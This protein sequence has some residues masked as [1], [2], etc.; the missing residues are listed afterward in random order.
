[1]RNASSYPDNQGPIEV[2]ETH[3]SWVFLTDRYAYKLKKPVRF[4][5]LDFSIPDL[6]HRACL[7]EVRL[8]R[9][10]APDVYL[11]VLPITQN[12]VG[13]IT[14]N[15]EGQPVDW[16]VQMRRLPATNA[17][18]AVLRAGKLTSEQAQ[19]IVQH[20]TSSYTRLLPKPINANVYREA[21]NR[22]IRANGVALLGS[23]PGEQ[24]RTRRIQ[25]AQ[26]RYLNVGADLI[27][28]RATAGRVVEGHG[29]L[30]P[31]H[32]YVNGG[33]IVIDCIEFSDELR[34]VDI[35]DELSFLGME[36]E[37]LGD[38]GLGEAVLAEYQRVSGDYLP[39]SLLSFYRCYR[40]LVRAKV[41]LIRE[42]QQT[43]DAASLS[44]DLVH[45]YIDLADRYAKQLG[46]PILLIVGGLM[47]SGK[48]TLAAKLAEAFGSEL[49][50]TDQIRHGLMGASE[51]PAGYGEG[52]YRPDMRSRVYDE[53]FRQ[54]GELLKDG[55]SVVLD[56]TFLT[57]CLR[58][59]AYDLGRRS[60]AMC[61]HMHCTCPRQVAYARIQK[62]TETGQSQSEA[63]TELYD[64]QAQDLEPPWADE[65]T[66]TVD[67]TSAV[68]E[69]HQA[70][71][72][73]LK[74]LASA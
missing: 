9:R 65:P 17:L 28:S 43:N 42:Q 72:A 39:E 3:I 71:Y 58:D 5:F 47:G 37:R 26:L 23:L 20:L 33:P 52:N 6:R 53:L 40:A 18:D 51:S 44:A 64:L 50:S 27:G 4:E 59:R 13:E 19:S 63:R 62:R 35:A 55:Q 41:A 36:C 29:D 74:R 30:R 31:E 49:L 38:G 15:G 69:Q 25:S 8:N 56:G 61:L 48:S 57:G 7:D 34:T 32:I 66:I 16:V 67:T 70:V 73:E 2:V 1:M 14:L 22:H 10:L 68:S 21:L 46:P 12:S 60:G 45:Q 54:A 24:S 11:G